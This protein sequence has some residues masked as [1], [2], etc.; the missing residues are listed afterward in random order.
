MVNLNSPAA[1]PRKF[2]SLP[3]LHTLRRHRLKVLHSYFTKVIHEYFERRDSLVSTMSN[4]LDERRISGMRTLRA[5]LCSSLSSR[6]ARTQM[7]HRACLMFSRSVSILP[8]GMESSEI[9]YSILSSRPDTSPSRT[10]MTHRACLIR[11]DTSPSR[12]QMTHR[13]CLMLSFEATVNTDDPSS[14]SDV[15]SRSCLAGWNQDLYKFFFKPDI[16]QPILKSGGNNIIISGTTDG[17]T[18]NFGPSE[19]KEIAWSV[20]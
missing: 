19:K 18:F 1:R 9:L 10:Q 5:C 14:L 15:Q 20:G 8:G 13:A 12:T 11:P 3:S 6:P 7:T 17:G 2:L 4:H 16:Y